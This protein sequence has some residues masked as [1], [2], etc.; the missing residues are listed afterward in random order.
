MAGNRR[1]SIPGSKLTRQLSRAG[2]LNEIHN[3][4]YE[5]Y[6]RVDKADIPSRGFKYGIVLRARWLRA[7]R[8]DKAVIPSRRVATNSFVE[9]LY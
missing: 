2:D 6:N 3:A 7:C 4:C 1:R 9:V 8:V 5:A